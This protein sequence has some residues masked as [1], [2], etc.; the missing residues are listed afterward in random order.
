M[1]SVRIEYLNLTLQEC[2]MSAYLKEGQK[3]YNE[4]DVWYVLMK[5]LP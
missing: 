3:L 2:A 1:V 4:H 5:Y